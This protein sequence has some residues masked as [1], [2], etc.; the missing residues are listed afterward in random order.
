MSFAAPASAG[1]KRDFTPKFH[2][3]FDGS[4]RSVFTSLSM[5]KAKNKTPLCV[6][7]VSSFCWHMLRSKGDIVISVTLILR[8]LKDIPEEMARSHLEIQLEGLEINEV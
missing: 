6:V 3:A 5:I 2:L 8:F 1:T 4:C 7:G